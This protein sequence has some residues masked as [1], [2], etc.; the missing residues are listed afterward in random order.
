MSRDEEQEVLL[1]ED[2]KGMLVRLICEETDL[3]KNQVRKVLNALIHAMVPTLIKH[4][5]LKWPSFV[6]FRVDK[7]AERMGR[8]PRNGEPALIPAR[9]VIKV[10]ISK[11]L[12]NCLNNGG[13]YNFNERKFG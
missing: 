10:S 9:D 3:S 5:Q 12:V 7:R 1:P 6:N 8:N 4:R 11:T 13:E 2:A